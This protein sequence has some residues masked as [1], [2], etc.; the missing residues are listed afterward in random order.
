M[1]IEGHAAVVNITRRG[2][3]EERVA[4]LEDEI[5]VEIPRL[6]GRIADEAIKHKSVIESL[7]RDLEG[8][9][10]DIRK[11]LK[12]AVAGG[13]DL[14]YIGVFFVLAGTILSTI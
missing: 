5:S 14:E 13:L 3:L 8:E 2:S 9:D 10:A 4:A 6:H 12:E 7:Q 11:F 1:S